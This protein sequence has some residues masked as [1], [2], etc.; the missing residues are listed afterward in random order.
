ME[1]LQ[2]QSMLFIERG[3]WKLD[4]PIPLQYFQYNRLEATYIIALTIT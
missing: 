4:D 2:G 1:T 3:Q